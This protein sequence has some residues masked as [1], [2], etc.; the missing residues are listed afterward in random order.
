MSCG[1]SSKATLK[2]WAALGSLSRPASISVHRAPSRVPACVLLGVLTSALLHGLPF[3]LSAFVPGRMEAEDSSGCCTRR[4][5]STSLTGLVTGLLPMQMPVHSDEVPTPELDKLLKDKEAS[6]RSAE[7]E[8]SRS[9]ILLDQEKKLQKREK[10]ILGSDDLEGEVKLE[11]EE[12]KLESKDRAEEKRLLQEE[13]KLDENRAR[14][15]AEEEKL[16]KKSR[17]LADEEDKLEAV[18]KSLRADEGEL[19]EGEVRLQ[20]DEQRIR[21]KRRDRALRL[22]SIIDVAKKLQEDR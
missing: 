17:E 16:I 6:V 19:A 7:A 21:L 9:K 4:S 14:L 11:N 20:A 8:L 12:G 2:N 22:S 15:L 10:A 13:K 5:L 18:L 3:S 1:V